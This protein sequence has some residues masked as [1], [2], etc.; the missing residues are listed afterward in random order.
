[1]SHDPNA[2]FY[3][4]NQEQQDYVI[5]TVAKVKERG[6]AAEQV[7]QTLPDGSEAYAYHGYRGVHWGINGAGADYQCIARGIWPETAS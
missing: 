3:T 6:P 1:M 7:T 5:R 2:E 4:L